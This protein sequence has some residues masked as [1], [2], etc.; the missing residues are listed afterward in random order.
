MFD[1]IEIFCKSAGKTF[2]VCLI[3]LL[4]IIVFFI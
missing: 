1:L 2:V 4:I 3:V